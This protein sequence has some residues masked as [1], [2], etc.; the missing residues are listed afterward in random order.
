MLGLICAFKYFI[1]NIEIE[2]SSAC[3]R[4]CDYCPQSVLSRRQVL[5]PVDTF[6]KIANELAGLNYSGTLAFHQYNEPLLVQDHLFEC[7]AIARSVLPKSPCILFTNG[8][9]LTP[10]LLENLTEKGIS[11]INMTCHVDPGTHYDFE[12][13]IGKIVEGVDKL[14]TSR[15]LCAIRLHERKTAMP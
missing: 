8:D 7:L 13:M 11:Q 3:N 6:E 2:I 5:L 10:T 15:H 4:R 14:M 1:K 9:M 12:K